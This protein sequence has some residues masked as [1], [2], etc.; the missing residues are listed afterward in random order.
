MRCVEK[1]NKFVDTPNFQK[2]IVSFA[3]IKYKPFISYPNQYSQPNQLHWN[4]QTTN[5]IPVCLQHF[6][7]VYFRQIN[8]TKTGIY[9]TQEVVSRISFRLFSKQRRLEHIYKKHYVSTSRSSKTGL[10]IYTK[11]MELRSQTN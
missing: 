4:S 6:F 9:T 8:P 10:Q 11:I 7:F 5:S 1:I 2:V 3:I